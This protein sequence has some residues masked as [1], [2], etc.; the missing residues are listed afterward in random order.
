MRDEIQDQFGNAIYLT[1]ERWEHIIEEHSELDGH[2]AEV[3]STV[4]SGKRSQDP[5]IP[6]KFFYNKKLRQL[7]EGF[8]EIEVVV[9]YR[10]QA[11][12]P[13]NFVV[14]AYCV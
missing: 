4:R 14:T 9:V 1:D 7:I 11:D 5:L 2:R 6:N 3:L 12:K 13:N 10:W 8:D